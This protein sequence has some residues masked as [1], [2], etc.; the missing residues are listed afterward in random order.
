MQLWEPGKVSVIGLAVIEESWVNPGGKEG[1]WEPALP[2]ASPYSIPARE[3]G[4][5]LHGAACLA[6]LWPARVLAATSCLPSRSLRNFL[7]GQS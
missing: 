3:A 1:H 2:L 7:C 6:V 5:W 4:P